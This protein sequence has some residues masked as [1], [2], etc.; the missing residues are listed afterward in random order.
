MHSMLLTNNR[1]RALVRGEL[2]VMEVRLEVLLRV[3]LLMIDRVV[4]CSVKKK[5]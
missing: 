2:M 3:V 1:Q 5:S 4:R